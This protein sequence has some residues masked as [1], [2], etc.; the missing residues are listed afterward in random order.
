MGTVQISFHP[1]LYLAPRPGERVE[2][3]GV[4]LVHAAV[5]TRL[6]VPEWGEA[7]EV[8]LQLVGL[9][10]E[11]AWTWWPVDLSGRP[12]SASPPSGLRTP[13][14]PKLP[15]GALS[16]LARW[17]QSTR[18]EVFRSPETGLVSGV[19]EDLGTFRSRVLAAARPAVLAAKDTGGEA[20]AEAAKVLHV[21]A[22]SME[23]RELVLDGGSMTRV[24]AGLLVVPSLEGLRPAGPPRDPMVSGRARSG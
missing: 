6:E 2:G 10:D 7:W 23:R 21:L 12:L 9:E 13:P 8:H 17:L 4:A 24:Q 14:E 19:G 22:S 18:M 1:P 11:P 16:G 5:W 3:G 15:E 20:L